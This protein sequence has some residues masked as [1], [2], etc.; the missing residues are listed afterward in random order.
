MTF[1]TQQTVWQNNCR[2]R[3]D[4]FVHTSNQPRIRGAFLTPVVSFDYLVGSSNGG[5]VIPI[6]SAA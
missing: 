4:T 3:L 1:A 5:M 2:G 6:A